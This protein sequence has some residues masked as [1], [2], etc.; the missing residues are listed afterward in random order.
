MDLEYTLVCGGTPAIQGPYCMAHT[1]IVEVSTLISDGTLI[2]CG[3]LIPGGT[4]MSFK[5]NRNPS[6]IGSTKKL[7]SFCLS[8][9]SLTCYV[10]GLMRYP[11]GYLENIKSPCI[12]VKRPIFNF[13][14][15][16]RDLL[17]IELYLKSV[18]EKIGPIRDTWSGISFNYFILHT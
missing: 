2:S 7:W 11:Y 12:K 14:S 18:C 3:T 4:L 13:F 5:P 15:M 16:S 9:V 17:W 10:S 8:V 1:W 6:R